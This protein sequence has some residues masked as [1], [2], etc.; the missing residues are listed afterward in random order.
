MSDYHES[1]LLQ[2]AIGELKVKPGGEYIDATLGG[3]G[4]TL[5]ILNRGGIVLGIDVDEDA[6]EHV[7]NELRIRNDELSI[8]KRLKLIRGNFAKIEE[9]AK[10]NGFSRVD[11]ILLDLGVSSHQLDKGDRGFSFQSDAPLDMR[12]DTSLGV[13][14]QDL[15]NGLTKGELYDLL[16]KYGEEEFTRPIVRNIISAREV[17]PIETTRELAQVIFRAYPI[18]YKKIHPATKTFQALRIAVND[19]LNSLKTALPQAIDLLESKG[20]ESKGRLVVITFHSLEDKIV[21]KAFLDFESNNL[22]RVMY[23]KPIEPSDSEK[24]INNRSRSAKMRVFEKN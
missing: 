14:A 23:K 16:N 2:E 19:E 11:G 9:I 4:H 17:K 12:M 13:K 1:V 3:G 22:G 24:N 21:K 5:E 8:G 15:I 20:R 18:K 7:R 6:I 10:E